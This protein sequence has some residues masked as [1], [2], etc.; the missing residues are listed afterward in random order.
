MN[1][2]LATKYRAKFWRRQFVDVQ[3]I[4]N[5]VACFPQSIFK[6]K[7]NKMRSDWRK[8]TVNY[9]FTIFSLSVRTGYFPPLRVNPLAWSSEAIYTVTRQ[10]YINS[11]SATL[12]P[13]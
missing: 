12:V 8:S 4:T 5:I 1:S 6:S 13:D 9:D 3:P 10:I 2:V 11:D 7:E